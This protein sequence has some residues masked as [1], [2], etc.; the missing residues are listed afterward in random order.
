MYRTDPIQYRREHGLLDYN[1]QMAMIVQKVVGQRF[2]DFFSPL[3]AGVMA[4][5]FPCRWNPRIKSEDGLLRIVVGLGTR[6]VDTMGSDHPRMIPLS[7]P[8]LR[9]EDEVSQIVKYSQKKV[10]VINL[11]KGAF[12]TLD[13]STLAGQIDTPN[14]SFAVSR[15]EDSE[16]R[17]PLYKTMSNAGNHLCITFENFVRKSAFLP[18]IR[19]V[20]N[21]LKEAYNLPVDVE[22][23]WDGDKLYILQCRTLSVRREIGEVS[24]PEGIADR[25]ILFEVHSGLSNC[26]LRNLEYIVS[27][28]PKAYGRIGDDEKKAEV[29][30]IV[31][32]INQALHDKAFVLLG[33]GG[34]G[35]DDVNHGVSVGYS[36]INNTRLL[37][38]IAF[39]RDGS[40][41]VVSNGTHFSKDLIER[42]IVTL[43]IHSYG[44]D[45]FKEIFVEKSHNRLL[46]FLENSKEFRK[47]VYVIHVPP[48]TGGKYLHVDLDGAAQKGIGYFGTYYEV[49]E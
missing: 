30:R 4:S 6:A 43:P 27:V 9:P 10:D 42:N 24:I 31:S 44:D 39:S 12:E 16:V 45:R 13:I 15:V 22:F 26:V 14:I 1:E 35:S 7:H 49:E 32:G 23:A 33:P 47:I 17:A 38:E 40:T 18:L 28:D 41:P 36:D 46:S 3:A 34:W 2:G 5:V 29:A 21:R 11:K 37:A 19:K 25:D 48:E 8:E 20:M